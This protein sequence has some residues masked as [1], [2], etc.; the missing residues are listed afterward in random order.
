MS[1]GPIEP[2]NSNDV[3]LV[4]PDEVDGKAIV[5]HVAAAGEGVLEGEADLGRFAELVTH[6]DGAVEIGPPADIRR[7]DVGQVSPFGAKRVGGAGTRVLEPVEFD[8]RIVA[9][10]IG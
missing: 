1:A 3:R 8:Q 7:T 6:A 10:Q 2:P 4:S 9:V 5:Q